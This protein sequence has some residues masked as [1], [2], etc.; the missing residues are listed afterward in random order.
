MALS[1][2]CCLCA[3][4][5]H[6]PQWHLIRCDQ[7]VISLQC[8]RQVILS[9]ATIL[10]SHQMWPSCHLIRCEHLAILPSHRNVTV[11]SSHQMRPSCHLILCEGFAL[12]LDATILPSHWNVTVLSSHQ[13]REHCIA[14]SSNET[15]YYIVIYVTLSATVMAH[16]WIIV[17]F[18]SFSL[19]LKLLHCKTQGSF[20]I[21]LQDP[22][23][24]WASKELNKN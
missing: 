20:H 3:W 19:K 17:T 24:N 15:A 6:L 22:N 12:S 18:T 10:S 1:K 8:D 9:D 5:C 11:R 14:I 4:Q 7:L 21:G 23:T 2:R 13:M 16:H